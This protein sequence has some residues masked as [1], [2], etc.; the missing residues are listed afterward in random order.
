MM[1]P[2][3]SQDFIYYS[4]FLGGQLL[5][6]LKRAASAIRNVK[7]PIAS[8]RA[9]IY[10]NWDVLLIRC[11]LELPFYWAY[12]HYAQANDILAHFTTWKI[13]L[14]LPQAAI[15][16]FLL[17]YFV[18]SQLDKYG[19]SPKAPAWLKET[20]PGVTVYASHTVEA[21]K[22]SAGADVTVEK[23]ITVEKT[24]PVV[25]KESENERIKP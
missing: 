9:F 16:I 7:N 8:R 18:D 4:A 14:W 19:A 1:T 24:P 22:D 15:A 13:P 10:A 12:R 6:V 3:L 25:P 5:F 11:V 17:G 2:H 20:I 21:G 23:T